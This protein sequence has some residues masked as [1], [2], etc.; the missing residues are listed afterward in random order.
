MRL[1][2]IF[3]QCEKNHYWRQLLFGFL[4][5]FN[6]KWQRNRITRSADV[7]QS[8]KEYHQTS[9]LVT[10]SGQGGWSSLDLSHSIILLLNIF[11][12][13]FFFSNLNDEINELAVFYK[14][15]GD[16]YFV[17][18]HYASVSSARFIAKPINLDLIFRLYKLTNVLVFLFLWAKENPIEIRVENL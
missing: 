4:K 17:L 16:F 13:F 11:F 6:K 5:T 10:G 14:R 12:C 15:H 1:L 8:L 2:K 9:W 7:R 3:A 18:Y